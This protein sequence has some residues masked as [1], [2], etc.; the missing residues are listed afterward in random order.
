MTSHACK[1]SYDNKRYTRLHGDVYQDPVK[2]E[3]GSTGW[4]YNWCGRWHVDIMDAEGK[5][6]A[7]DFNNTAVE[8]AVR[9][10]RFR[11]GLLEEAVK[12]FEQ[13][14]ESVGHALIN[15]VILAHYKMIEVEENA[16]SNT[17]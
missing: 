11:V 10:A 4:R 17:V 12:C 8:R 1:W 13:G 6:L 3:C 15:K 2:C 16:D 7:V 14:E 9:D 5:P